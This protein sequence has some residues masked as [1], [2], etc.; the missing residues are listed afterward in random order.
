MKILFITSTR[1][2]DAVLSTGLLDYMHD[3]WPEARV[4]VACGPLPSSIFEGFPNVDKIIPLKKKPRSGHWVELWKAVIGTHWDMVVDLRNSAVSR[5]IFARKRY[6][7][8]RRIDPLKHKVEQMADVMRLPRVPSPAL[9]FSEQQMEFARAM[10]PAGKIV[11]GIGP[12]AN[13]IGKTWPA[14]NFIEVIK[15]LTSEEGLMPDAYVAVFAAPGEEA[16]ARPVLESV[17]EDKRI[18]GIAKGN[19]GEVAA[20][21]SLCDFYIGNDSGLMH[22]AAASSVPTLGLFGPSYPHIY[23]PWGEHTAYIQTPQT[24]DEL[25]DF[26]GYNAKTLDH[27]LMNGLQ[28]QTVIN[29]IKNFDPVYERVS[30]HFVQKDRQHKPE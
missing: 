15:W 11:L 20:A 27:S 29:I 5:L 28:S 4:T 14:E 1:L 26:E 2:G 25:I 21:I 6:I 10:I 12:S 13:W 16:Q 30:N 9:Y 24:Y 3:T 19:P 18:D 8:G 17:P 22:C 7:F 23:A